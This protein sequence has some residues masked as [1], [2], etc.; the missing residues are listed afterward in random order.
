ML[1]TSLAEVIPAVVILCTQLWHA[2]DF[3][4]PILKPCS[5]YLEV[6][7][8]FLRFMSHIEVAI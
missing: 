7:F 6:A 5:I 4:N 1:M 3:S 2:S 8:L